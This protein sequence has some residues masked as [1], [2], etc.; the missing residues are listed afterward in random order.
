M[1]GGEVAVSRLP[2]WV[3]SMPIRLEP[4]D[5]DWPVLFQKERQRLELRL[6]FRAIEHISSTSVP[7]LAAKPIL[8]VMVGFERLELGREA[9]PALVE[10]GYHYVPAYEVA[11]PDRLFLFKGEPRT[12]HLHLTRVGSSFWN[13]RLLFRDWLRAHPEDRQA[14]QTLKAELATR[15]DDTNAYAEAKGP[16]VRGVLERARAHR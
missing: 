10:A 2:L 13:E 5:P 12:H 6:G 15:F 9:L 7:D 1:A 8:D 11:I 3:D 16:F 14:Y 4:Y